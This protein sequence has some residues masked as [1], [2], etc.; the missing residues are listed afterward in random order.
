[1]RGRLRHS[2]VPV[3]PDAVSR[4]RAPAAG[5]VSRPPLAI[6]VDVGGGA[7]RITSQAGAWRRA[8][9]LW[10]QL[11]WDLGRA[12]ELRLELDGYDTMA[13]EMVG[14]S[15]GGWRYGSAALGLRWPMR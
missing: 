12:R 8:L 3:R 15:T 11:S 13:G 2:R 5:D 7:A 4:L 10:S 1:M 14:A 6:A 9:R